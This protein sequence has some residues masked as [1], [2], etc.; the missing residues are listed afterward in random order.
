MK[1]QTRQKSSIISLALLTLLISVALLSF[2]GCD[3]VHGIIPDMHEWVDATCTESKYCSS[4]GAAEGEPLG[5]TPEVILGKAAT[6]TETGL[7]DGSRCSVCGE[8]L[9]AQETVP[10]LGHSHTSTVI[11]PTCTE[12]GYTTYTCHC[13][14]SYIGDYVDALGHKESD[15]II[16]TNATCTENGSKHTVCTVCKATVKTEVIPALGHSHTSAVTAPTCTEQGY[17]TYTCH[18]GD[19][20]IGDYIDA[21]GHSESDW[22]I[23][24]NATCTENGAKHTACTVCGMTLNITAIP[25]LGHTPKIIPAVNATCTETGLTEG[26]KCSVCGEILKAQETMPATKE[27]I[28]G[29]DG[30]CSICGRENVSE[31]LEFTISSDGTYCTVKG[32]GTCT[33]TDIIIPSTYEGVLVTSI[34]N[35]AFSGCY[36]ITSITIP[37]GV[38]SIGEDA[39]NDCYRLTS[40][41]VDEGNNYYK[42]I[43][44]NLYT[45]DGTIFVCCAMSKKDV[46]IPEGVISIGD[47]AL[48]GCSS[49]TSIT[50]SNSVTSIGEHAFS[51]CSNLTSITIPSSVTSIGTYAL[52]N[53][54]S[55]TNVNFGENSQL[56]SIGTYAFSYCDRLASISFGKNSQLTSIGKQAFFSS[57]RL[58]SV[59]FGENSQLISIG[60][61]AFSGCSSLTSITIPN[62]VTS[63]GDNAFSGCTK[64]IQIENGVSYVDKWVV[65][66]DTSVASVTLRSDTVGIGDYV[67]N[68]CSG[69]TS[70]SVPDG[71]TRIGDE[72]FS[73]CSSLTNVTFGEN[74]QLTSIGSSAFDGCSS[75][76]SINIPDSVTSIGDYAFYGCS[77]LASITIPDSVTGIGRSVF[78]GCS[79]LASITIPESVTSIGIHALSNCYS[80][81]NVNFGENS[82]L[83]NIEK[84]AFYNCYSLAGVTIPESVTSIGERAFS[85]CTGLYVIYNCSD[86]TLTFGSTENGE[87]AY[88]AKA[89]VGADG[90]VAYNVESGV[91]YTLTDDGLLFKYQSKKYSLIA[92]AGGED[93]VTI[94]VSF[95][96]ESYDLYHMRG[97]V[98][99]IIPEGVLSL[100]NE[101]FYNCRSLV[102]ITLPNS[103]T[104]IGNYAFSTCRNLTSITIPEGVLTL[105]NYVF[106]YCSSLTNIIIADSV[107]SIG[108]SAFLSCSKLTDVYYTGTE[109]EWATI[110][111]NSN[112]KPLQNATI[113]Y[114]YSAE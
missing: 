87:L 75:L 110:E 16:D 105:G 90:N 82:Q 46:T 62:S 15:W 27:H 74:S 38:A 84:Q 78:S 59:D 102:S 49:L 113:H 69:L 70:I 83:T 85:G 6:C 10:A 72:M 64:L 68:K 109:A 111:I 89:I 43:D 25:A 107:T 30:I 14:D 3:T 97:V 61:Q 41:V 32:I 47:Y 28:Y 21:L 93:T 66:C 77:S 88:Y 44:G 103:L 52:T 42:S 80:L 95:N 55:L 45:K 60:K 76:T 23:D 18:C 104:S 36:N 9:T 92:Y 96:G 54:D 53:C 100:G 34:G 91:T 39:F 8:I 101:A 29:D 99:V 57:S 20:Y 71:V 31:G 11:A 7:T 106:E 108:Y 19:S 24:T 65:A 17:N 58:T 4:C 98:S 81:T 12:Q 33:D 79:S 56:T 26:S 13:G 94:P 114:S 86:I 1:S 37:E 40:F 112:N 67:F 73:G 35:Y 22:I 48:D 50:I 2:S 5:H 63:I 51:G